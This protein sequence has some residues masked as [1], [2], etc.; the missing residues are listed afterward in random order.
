[1]LLSTSSSSARIKKHFA[2]S[3]WL[4]SWLLT[5]ILVVAFLGGWEGHWRLQGYVPTV[6]DDW[7]LWA[8]LRRQLTH[9]EGRSVVLVGASRIQLGLHP[10]IFAHAAAIRPFMLAIDGNSPLPVLR[11]LAEDPNFSG[12]VICG[13]IPQWLAEE[14]ITGRR[15]GKWIRKYKQQQWSSRL[16]TKLATGVQQLFVFRFPGL[17]P[18]R[19]WRHLVHNERLKQVY[20]PMRPDR[21]R[22]ADYTRSDLVRLKRAREK[23]MR[24]QV[25]STTPLTSAAFKERI[26]LMNGWVEKIQQRGGQVI[27]LRMPSSGVI[28]E[29]EAVTWPRHRYWD[30][31]AAQMGGGAVHFE[32]YPSLAEFQCPDGSH[33]DSGHAELFTERLVEILQKTYQ[34][35]GKER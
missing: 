12:L 32:D 29:I 24:Q 25:L 22:P 2:S 1:M 13:L 35:F 14:K 5:M 8:D 18:G 17:S 3:L 9:R 27:F 15:A 33:L 10:D 31:F 26:G 6:E 4:R 7:G 11:N 21:Y 16:E 30:L 20:A 19:V 28:R 34:L 23:R